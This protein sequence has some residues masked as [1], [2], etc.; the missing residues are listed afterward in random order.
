MPLEILRYAVTLKHASAWA[1]FASRRHAEEWLK[2]H[3]HYA[4]AEIVNQ[5]DEIDQ[6]RKQA[7]HYQNLR[8]AYLDLIK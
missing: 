4:A 3:P 5:Q 7:E 1:T 2:A 8:N 6:Q